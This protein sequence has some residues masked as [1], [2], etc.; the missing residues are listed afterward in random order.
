MRSTTLCLLLGEERSKGLVRRPTMWKPSGATQGPKGSP[1]T[2]TVA[3]R[4]VF[5]EMRSPAS[6][7]STL[8]MNSS[9]SSMTSSTALLVRMAVDSNFSL[10]ERKRKTM[11]SWRTWTSATSSSFFCAA[12]PASRM[13]PFTY[14]WKLCSPGSRGLP[15]MIHSTNSSYSTTPLAFLSMTHMILSKSRSGK[16]GFKPFITPFSSSISMVPLPLRSQAWKASFILSPC[17]RLLG[18]KN[19]PKRWSHELQRMRPASLT[20]SC[21]GTTCEHEAHLRQFVWKTS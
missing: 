13:R 5:I 19:L 2:F 6:V 3:K 21:F 20:I 4:P 8:P 10:P 15:A 16:S 9:G 14:S 12:A 7:N 17:G 18:T 11:P 1:S